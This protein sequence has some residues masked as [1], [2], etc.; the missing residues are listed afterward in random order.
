MSY[1]NHSF[2]ATTA[3]TG[4]HAEGDSRS[5]LVVAAV[6]GLSSLL[7]PGFPA[8]AKPESGW[9]FAHAGDS[10]EN[11][12]VNLLSEILYLAYEKGRIVSRVEA[13]F[14]RRGHLR[15]RLVTRPAPSPPACEV[16]SVTYHRL[17]LRQRGRL[18]EIDFVMDV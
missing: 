10:L 12:L 3:D 15:C 1:R 4:I 7:F 18:L 8:A 9:E 17:A 6:E 11:A 13:L 5:E 2:F 16:K 14:V